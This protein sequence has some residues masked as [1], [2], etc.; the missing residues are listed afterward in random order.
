MK[1]QSG[2]LDLFISPI[3]GKLRS[4]SQFP[5]LESKD[6]IIIGD[7]QGNAIVSPALIDVRLDI[8]ELRALLQKLSNLNFVLQSGNFISPNAQALDQLYSGFLYNNTGG[9]LSVEVPGGGTISLPYGHIFVG[10]SSDL[11]QPL[12][13]LNKQLLIGNVS[14]LAEPITILHLDNMANLG[15]QKIFR[16][17]AL[18]RPVESDD[19]TTAESNI[20]GLLSSLADLASIVSAISSTVDALSSAVDALETGLATI[21]G[22]AAI[23]FL[24]LQ[25][26]GLLGSVSGLDS[27]L[28]T[29]EEDIDT[30]QGQVVDIYNQ[31]DSINIQLISIN[32]QLSDL[33]EAVETINDDIDA[34]NLAIFD[35]NT[36]LDII[37]DDISDIN[38]RIDNLSASFEGDVQGSGLLSSPINLELMLTL[39]EIKKAEDTVDLNDNKMIGLNCNQPG[40]FKDAINLGFLI[41]LVSGK[42]KV[43]WS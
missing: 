1:Y 5:S 35:I 38:T 9:V 34:I 30:L 7:Y 39:D 18:G 11:A 6:Y 22:F 42:V 15:H 20:G 36:Q 37:S 24:Q 43:V 13:L 40:S 14:N 27:R 33:N 29:A 32:S 8:V 25:V 12:A 4:I 16:G 41:A 17:N 3:T 28:T 26:L 19:L 23:I 10:D 2:F 31:L 21:G